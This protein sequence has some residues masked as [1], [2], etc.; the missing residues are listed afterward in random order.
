MQEGW[1]WAPLRG[2]EGSRHHSKRNGRVNTPPGGQGGIKRRGSIHMRQGGRKGPSTTKQCRSLSRMGTRCAATR[3]TVCMD[4]FTS[5]FNQWETDK[6]GGYATTTP[7]GLRMETQGVGGTGRSGRWERAN[8]RDHQRRGYGRVR[9]CS[10][11]TARETQRR[12]D[13][14]ERAWGRMP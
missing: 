5:P 14:T 10:G 3:R 9:P 7:H 11:G 12:D 8:P 2:K 13:G 1:G 4:L 6:R